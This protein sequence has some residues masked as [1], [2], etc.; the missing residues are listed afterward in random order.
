MTFLTAGENVYRQV[1]TLLLDQG[2]RSRFWSE[3][4]LLYE[5]SQRAP[6]IAAYTKRAYTLLLFKQVLLAGRFAVQSATPNNAIREIE[7]QLTELLDIRV[8][9]DARARLARAIKAAVDV[10]CKPIAAS[11]RRAVLG[12]AMIWQC[13]LC[14]TSL[15]SED[16]DSPHRVSLDHLW[17]SSLGGDSVEENLLP[18]CLHC[19]QAKANH[20]QWESLGVHNLMLS[21]YPSVD[22]LASVTRR[23]K[24]GLFY[25]IA[26]TRAEKERLSLRDALLRHGPALNVRVRDES[27]PAGFFDLALEA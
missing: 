27:T 2:R 5:V 4:P 25:F 1:Q 8:A 14:G 16:R 12:T 9:S 10:S 22:E 11:V 21:P 18:A 15:F 3:L 6:D 24:I 20:V 7:R 26:M 13:Y 17:P 19:Q 23:E